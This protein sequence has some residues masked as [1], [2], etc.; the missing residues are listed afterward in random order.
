MQQHF[1]HAEGA[2][3][4][5]AIIAVVA[6]AHGRADPAASGRCVTWR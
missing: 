1:L 4:L 6:V 2:A 3:I 5:V